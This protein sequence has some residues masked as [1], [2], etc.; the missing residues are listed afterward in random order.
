MSLFFIDKWETYA[1]SVKATPNRMPTKVNFLKKLRITPEA[2]ALIETEIAEVG[3]EYHHFKG[4]RLE[5]G[6]ILFHVTVPNFQISEYVVVDAA[7]HLLPE[8]SIHIPN[9]V[10]WSEQD[11]RSKLVIIESDAKPLKPINK[12]LDAQFIRHRRV[13]QCQSGIDHTIGHQASN[14]RMRPWENIHCPFWAKL[15]TTQLLLKPNSPE[16]MIAAVQPPFY[17]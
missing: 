2:R 3:V 16:G 13:Y 9:V 6:T 15:T 17:A 11:A 8:L 7:Q 14:T 12:N 10:N 1:K 5:Q 4:T